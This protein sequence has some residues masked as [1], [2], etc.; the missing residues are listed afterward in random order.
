MVSSLDTDLR[1]TPEPEGPEPVTETLEGHGGGADSDINPDPS[2]PRVQHSAGDE[3]SDHMTESLARALRDAGLD[4]TWQGDDERPL[5]EEGEAL[6][7]HEDP[8][9][10]EGTINISLNS[11]SFRLLNRP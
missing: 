6:D 11:L 2:S 9:Y 10:S 5:H 3:P 8:F 7:G 4:G 1:A